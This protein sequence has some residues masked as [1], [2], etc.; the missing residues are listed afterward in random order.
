MILTMSGEDVY[1]KLLVMTESLKVTLSTGKG[2][3]GTWKSNFLV[4]T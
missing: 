2:I 1:I 3:E 4:K